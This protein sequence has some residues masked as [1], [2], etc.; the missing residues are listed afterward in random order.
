MGA[1]GGRKGTF[2]Q[3]RPQ[4]RIRWL[5]PVFPLFSLA[6][7]GAGITAERSGFLLDSATG[8]YFVPLRPPRDILHSPGRILQ[9]N[10]VIL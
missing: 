8:F 10:H 4:V 2:D 7:T 9:G 3:Y 5:S 6:K 1:W